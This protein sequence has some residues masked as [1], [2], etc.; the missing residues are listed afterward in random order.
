MLWSRDGQ[1]Q[2][3]FLLRLYARFANAEHIVWHEYAD[4]QLGGIHLPLSA[5]GSFMPYPHPLA[6]KRYSLDEALEDRLD[7]NLILLGAADGPELDRLANAL[8]S[9]DSH[10]Y[11]RTPFWFVG[12]DVVLL[13]LAVFYL[14]IILP[15][16]SYTTGVLASSLLVLVLLVAQVGWQI[17]QWQWLPMGTEIQFLLFGHLLMSLWKGNKEQSMQLQ[18]T[19]HG[20][21]YQLGLQLFRDGRS[22]DALLA[23]K[24]CFTSDAVLAL[25]YDLASQQERKRHYGEAVKTYVAIVSRRKNFRDAA[26]KVEKLM[27]FSSGGAAHL[28]SDTEVAKTLIISESS[29]NKPVLGRYEI[30]RELGRG[31]MGVVYLGRDPKI[32]R[33]VAIKTLSYGQLESHELNEF[34]QRFFREAEAAGRLNHPNIVTVYDVGEEHDLAFIAMDYIKGKALS[35][36]VEEHSLL[37]VADVLYI[38]AEVAD[39]LEYAH[40]NQIVHR[41]IKP[42]NIMYQAEEERIK[43]TDFGIA[44]IVDSAKTSTGDVLGSPLYMSPEQLKGGSVDRR[45][46]VYS[47]GVTLYQLL[48]GKL[49]FAGDNLANLTYNIIHAKPRSVRELRPDLPKGLPRIINRALH[50][51]ADKRYTSAAAMAEALRRSLADPSQY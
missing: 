25:M 45:T 27:A 3:S 42:A 26:E 7:N 46:D 16:L 14:T 19:A 29:I 9:M 35:A 15:K 37:P 47:L 2:S 49:P 28:G 10:N 18:A 13:L 44:R 51:E 17:T 33:Q 23:L 50:K 30:E 21:R 39:A 31:A 8:R 48:T 36:H 1:P 32:A 24:E 43:V 6:T 34:K 20:A 41:D 4:V 40:A 38:A 11:Y 5:D 22:D 12:V